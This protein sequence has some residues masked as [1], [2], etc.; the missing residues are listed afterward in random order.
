MRLSWTALPSSPGPPVSGSP[1][2]QGLPLNVAF[3]SPPSLLRRLEVQVQATLSPA[4]SCCS[5]Q[6]SATETPRMESE[7]LLPL[8]WGRRMAPCCRSLVNR[9]SLWWPNYRSMVRLGYRCL[10]RPQYSRIQHFQTGHACPCRDRIVRV[11]AAD[12]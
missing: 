11:V 2:D 7:L 3:L 12:L 6:C 5:S 8:L 10:C 1:N 4:T 9:C